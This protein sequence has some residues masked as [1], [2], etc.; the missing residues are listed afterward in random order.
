VKASANQGKVLRFPNRSERWR[1][2]RRAILGIVVVVVALAATAV[3]FLPVRE[4][5]V[6]GVATLSPDAVIARAGVG[7]G[8]RILFT[9]LGPIED[10][11]R[12][13]PAIRSARVE[14]SLPTSIVI[15]VVER[16]ALARLDLRPDVAVD[17]DGRMFPAPQGMKLP[18][19]IG[20]SGRVAQGG[21]VDRLS[22][23]VLR[24]YERFPKAFRERTGKIRLGE[25]LD[26]DWINGIRVRMGSAQRLE[27]KAA[28][29]LAVLEAAKARGK[30]LST[31]DVRSPNVPVS[32]QV[33]PPSPSP[34]PVPPFAPAV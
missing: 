3:A 32:R 31:I 4:V 21:A 10:R 22:A 26:V 19:I 25:E 6:V 7:G 1:T 12:A 24:A 2:A 13:L 9:K 17:G 29:A 18:T 11:V 15:T 23:T 30:R 33:P 14:R 27:A 8:E 5:R 20:W 28:A 34:S 16:V